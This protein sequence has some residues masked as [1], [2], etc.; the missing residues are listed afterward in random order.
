MSK[1]YHIA[2]D[3]WSLGSFWNRFRKSQELKVPVIPYL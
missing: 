2:F 3:L 1:K